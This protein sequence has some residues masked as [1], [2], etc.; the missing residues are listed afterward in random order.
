[1]C[2]I[3]LS[4]ILKLKSKMLKKTNSGSFF[5][6]KKLFTKWIPFFRFLGIG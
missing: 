4:K 2:L 1:M 6:M 3:L 5:T